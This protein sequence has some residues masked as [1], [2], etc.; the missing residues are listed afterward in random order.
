MSDMQD[1]PEYPYDPQQPPPW[2]FEAPPPPADHTDP[3]GPGDLPPRRRGRAA[4]AAVVAALLLVASGVAIGYGLNGTSSTTGHLSLG[5]GNTGGSSSGTQSIANKVT[6]GVVDVNTFANLGSYPFTKGGST[7]LGAGTGMILTSTGEVLTNNHVIEGATRIQVTSPALDQSW[8]ATV[9]GADP[10]HDVALIQLQG[11]SGLPTVP[12]S[13]TTLPVGSGVVAIGNALGQGGS[14]TVTRGSVT[15][16]GRDINVGDGRGGFEHL[17]NLIQTDAPIS[18]GDS[19]GPL[20]ST[21]GQVVGII[22]ASARADLSGP[23]SNVG[24][25]IPAT[26]ALGIVQQVRAGHGSSSIIIGPAGFLG[27]KVRPLPSSVGSGL[28]VSSGAFVAGVV[29]NTPAAR[30]GITTGSVITA[31]NGQ[32]VDSADTLGPALHVHKPGSTVQVTWVNSSGTH[33]STVQLV[34]GPAI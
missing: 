34:A 5:G 6:P 27:V 33:T 20:V 24:Y 9:L 23:T 12:V 19:G 29:P 11:A 3:G 15:A 25:A 28:G 7:P 26:D 30:A 31:V 10:T 21:S 32:S 16:T 18:P 2:L 17:Q 4:L 1:T 8:D 13:N 22:T 14:P